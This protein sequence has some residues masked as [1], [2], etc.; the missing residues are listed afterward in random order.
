IPCNLSRCC[1]NRDRKLLEVRA[2]RCLG[3]GSAFSFSFALSR[4]CIHVSRRSGHARNPP[5]RDS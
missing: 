5:N 4:P 2:C 1:P 3:H